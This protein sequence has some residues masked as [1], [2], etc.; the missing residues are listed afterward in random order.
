[1]TIENHCGSDGA[2][3]SLRLHFQAFHGALSEP[4]THRQGHASGLSGSAGSWNVS[5]QM[6]QLDHQTFIIP[7]WTTAP[8]TCLIPCETIQKKSSIWCHQGYHIS[9]WLRIW[10]ATLSQ[11]FFDVRLLTN[12]AGDAGDCLHAGGC[13]KCTKLQKACIQKMNNILVMITD[14]HESK[15]VGYI[16]P[17]FCSSAALS[18]LPLQGRPP[19]HENRWCFLELK[20]LWDFRIILNNCDLFLGIANL[21]IHPADPAFGLFCPRLDVDTLSGFA[22]AFAF[23]FLPVSLDDTVEAPSGLT[24]AVLEEEAGDRPGLFER[25]L[26]S[27]LDRT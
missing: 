20:R 22:F 13:W 24:T 27:Q 23:G 14:T 11:F 16:Q 4:K 10:H 6:N 3:P 1:M 26:W 7:N 19:H 2:P 21:L 17:A 18:V 5:L 8:Y 12:T 9:T 15:R 25:D